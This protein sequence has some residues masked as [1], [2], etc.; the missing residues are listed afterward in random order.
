M[1]EFRKKLRE[2]EEALIAAQESQSKKHNKYPKKNSLNNEESQQYFNM[3]NSAPI[4]L[5]QKMD[6]YLKIR[7]F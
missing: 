1:N 5:D 2:K 3:K 4:N 6:K 7:N